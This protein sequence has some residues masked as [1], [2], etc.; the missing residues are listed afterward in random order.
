MR[1]L[2]FRALAL[3][4]LSISAVNLAMGKA[5]LVE[6]RAAYEAPHH[7]HGNDFGPDFERFLS[8]RAA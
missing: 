8:S 2:F 4:V 3:F 7:F 6:G 5:P 1:N